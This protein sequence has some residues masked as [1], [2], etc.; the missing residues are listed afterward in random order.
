MGKTFSSI[1]V[2]FLKTTLLFESLIDAYMSKIHQSFNSW[3]KG[4]EVIFM[5][6]VPK[7]LIE[8]HYKKSQVYYPCLQL[9]VCDILLYSIWNLSPPKNNELQ[10]HNTSG[11][12]AFKM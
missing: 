3:Q 1:L 7:D 5:P 9:A 10:K 6:Q 2:F 11:K 12:I 4:N 8:M